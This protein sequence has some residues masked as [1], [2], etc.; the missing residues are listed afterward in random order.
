M[1]H[2]DFI[3]QDYGYATTFS[4]GDFGTQLRKQRFDIAPLHVTAR[5]APED[6]FQSALVL[7]LHA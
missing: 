1:K 2:P 6:Q 4:L 5:R 7:P 3:E